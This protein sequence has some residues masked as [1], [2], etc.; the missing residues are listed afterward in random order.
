MTSTAL[1]EIYRTH[2]MDAKVR[3]VAAEKVLSNIGCHGIPALDHEFCF[4]QIRRIVEDIT[5]SAMVRESS[6]YTK[7]R[8]L[9]S[10][11]N[12]RDHGIASKDW[13]APEILKR[14]VSLSPYALPIPIIRQTRSSESTINFDR[15]C[16]EVNH[17]R[18]IDLYKQSGGFLHAKNPLS[19]DFIDV[20]AE[21]RE[22][23]GRAPIVIKQALSFLR[24][25]LWEHGA[26]QLEWQND[27]DPFSIENAS[28]AWL[29]F[30]GQNQG[31][32]VQI[33]LAEARG[34]A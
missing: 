14:L 2:M 30:F 31:L 22:K 20:T 6:R 5:F 34:Y 16:I 11:E 1:H 32:E 27:E 3:I 4:L 21:E 19:G 23:Y 29:V 18:L 17:G 25:M 15:K 26:L 13:Q 24:E 8:E 28:A 10:Q 7:L 33:I 9:Q 12:P